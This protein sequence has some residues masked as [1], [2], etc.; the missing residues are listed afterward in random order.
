MAAEETRLPAIDPLWR[1]YHDD[2][3][4]DAR[5]QLLDRYIGLVH[6]TA[7]EIQ[8]KGLRDLDLDDLLSAGTL[9]LVQALEGFDPA[10]GLAFSTY[11][12]PRIRGAMLDELRGRDWTP[13]TVRTRRRRIGE[14][15][16]RLQQRLGR[17]PTAAEMAEALGTDLAT[18]WTWSRDADRRVMVALDQAVP[19]GSHEED[20]LY[21]TIP[22]QGT[23]EPADVLVEQERVRLLMESFELLPA[24]DRLVLTLYYY[25]ELSLK[26]IGAV[27]HVSESRVSQIHTRSLRR[28]RHYIRLVEEEA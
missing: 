1:R 19:S 23:R 8:R 21:E 4:I 28:L 6:H 16:A 14:V 2:R 12:M 17:S 3:D 11:A 24:K 18:Y 20:S 15:G 13:R 25:E 7:R 22:D 27:L 10:R 9:G 26:Q 5:T